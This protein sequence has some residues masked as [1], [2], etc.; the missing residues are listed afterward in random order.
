MKFRTIFVITIILIN[1][2]FFIVTT[3]YVST[4]F[5]IINF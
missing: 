2:K 5:D 4:N 1:M 3:P